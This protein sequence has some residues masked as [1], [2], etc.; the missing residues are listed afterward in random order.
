MKNKLSYIFNFFIFTGI[1]F[2]LSRASLNGIVYPFSYGMLFALA[3]ANQKVWVLVP[4]YLVGTVI[5]N[6]SFEGLIAAVATVTLLLI[7]YYIHIA[8]KKA[9]Q[10]WELYLFAFLSQSAHFIFS[11]LLGTSVIAI[12]LHIV[13]GLIL[14]YLELSLFEGVA[15]RGLSNKLTAT[16]L[17]AGGIILISLCAGLQSSDIYGFSLFKLFV[18]FGTLVLSNV[19]SIQ[20]ALLF[21]A[22][23]GIGGMLNS[24]NPLFMSPF[25][26]QAVF[27][28]IF[29]NA[30]RIFPA[31]AIVL[32]EVLSIFY[33]EL[34]YDG[35]IISIL[36]VVLAAIVFLVLP[37]KFYSQ[38]SLL[39]NV[40]YDRMAIKSV[41]NRNREIMQ[42]RLERLAEV[43]FEMNLVFKKL[44]KK[45][46]SED[47]AKEMLYEELKST[48]CQG[49]PDH[50]H[51]HR[52]FNEDTKKIF[53]QLITIALERGRITL[54]DLPSYLSS[55][56]NKANVLI[57][58][59]NTLT[60]QYKSY[61]S[62]VGNIDRTK[63][64]ISDQLEGVSGIMKTLSKE[65]DSV[66]ALDGGLENKIIEQLALSN[67]IC[68]DAIVYQKD[69]WTCK[70]TLVVRKED[71][72]KLS[73]S[74]TVS[75]ICK[76]KMCVSSV[77]PS[78][79]AGLVCVDL[80]T[81][82]AYD[83]IFGLASTPKGGNEISGDKHCIERLDGDRFIFA[84]CD[85][86]GNGEVASEKSET[87]ISLIENFYKAG[88]DS[89]IILSSVNKLLNL[90]GDDIFSSIDAC[91]V[92]L[93]NGIADFV[94]MGATTSYIRDSEGCRVVENESLPV[95][96]IESAKVK[97]KKE[98]L[99]EKSF[100]VLCS[101]G[102][103]DSFSTDNEF[104]DFLLSLKG[105]NPQS[106]AD[107]ILK[108]ALSKNNGYAVDDMT[109]LVVK[110]F[111]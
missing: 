27:V 12:L 93:K 74:D 98:V 49:C 72:N 103:N 91:I 7:P 50:K 110:I 6:Y 84:I 35:A 75:K 88:F 40:S 94:K 32:A 59:I 65:V 102:V 37:Q 29:K 82:P 56:C 2:L 19:S 4:A 104:K 60:K 77:R 89:E 85:G 63:L 100:I 101:D 26:L 64:L 21:S 95:G 108:M 99:R 25:I 55:R 51:C 97:T 90:E 58:E 62:L 24:N 79:K 5:N 47:E 54:L 18:A 52:T 34:Y 81:A 96:I 15:I 70:A 30:N 22:L 43:F 80:K 28:C 61:R 83:C 109:V 73:L 45:S 41:L 38:A 44:I 16:E 48:I 87:A 53:I 3:W 106:Q 10:K 92:D 78:E 111:N 36:P 8:L 107:E 17:I 13:I 11:L 66:I 105:A 23:A 39:F 1:F 57:S 68:M 31:V 9:M 14:L 20:N 46:A 69:N 76:N 67:I 71:A 33:F 86:M 42:R